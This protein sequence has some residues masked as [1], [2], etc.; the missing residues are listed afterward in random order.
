MRLMSGPPSL[1]IVRRFCSLV[2]YPIK[3]RCYWLTVINWHTRRFLF[4]VQQQCQQLSSLGVA[5]TT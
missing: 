4:R 1:R 2:V 3:D 5:E